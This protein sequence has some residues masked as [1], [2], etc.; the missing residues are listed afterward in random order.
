[1][2]RTRLFEV[3]PTEHASSVPIPRTAI[4]GRSHELATAT[5]LLQE[6][7]VR[8]VTLTGTGGVGKTR[9]ALE[10]ATMLAG[11][12]SDRVFFVDLSTIRDA[13]D[14]G[15][16]MA[17]ALGVRGSAEISSSTTSSTCSMRRHSWVICWRRRD[18]SPSSRPVAPY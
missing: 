12:F 13:S 4:I 11:R 6:S 1:M 2:L 17:T 9:L 15:K 18:P 5:L 16:A 7:G 8:L 14:V 3:Q 10:L